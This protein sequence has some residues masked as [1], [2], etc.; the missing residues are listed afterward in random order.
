MT[1]VPYEVIA[2]F[3]TVLRDQSVHVHLEA[4]ITETEINFVADLTTPQGHPIEWVLTRKELA[5]L[6]RIAEQRATKP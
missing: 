1:A 5:K 3:T 2:D 4:T 6:C